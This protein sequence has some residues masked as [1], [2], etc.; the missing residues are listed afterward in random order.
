MQIVLRS[1]L[2]L[3]V[4]LLP[5]SA[6]PPPTYPSVI[7]SNENHWPD[8][9]PA[10]VTLIIKPDG[11]ITWNGTAVSSDIFSKYLSDTAK[12]NPQ[13]V[14]DIFPDPSTP[15]AT[16]APILHK[17]QRGGIRDIWFGK[18]GKWIED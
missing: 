5:S 3:M 4:P 7:C 14:V 15:Y 16:L 12:I 8:I 11:K 10:I 6:Q 13:P 1:I 18:N 9:P 17:I 2:L